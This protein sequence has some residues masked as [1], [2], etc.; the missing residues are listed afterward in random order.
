MRP[1]WF[2]RNLFT[3]LLLTLILALSLAQ[4]GPAFSSQWL[5]SPDSAAP[6]D[7]LWVVRASYSD[8]AMIAQAAS[9]TEPWEVNRQAG[10][11][12]AGVNSRGLEKLKQLG[13]TLEID[14][15]LTRQM[16]AA[17]QPLAGQTSGIP[18]YPCYRTVEETYASA[19]NLVLIAPDLASWIDIGDSWEKTE[20]GGGAG[21][22]LNVLKLTNRNIPGPKPV[23]FIMAAMH[24]REY[25]TAE[26]AMRFAESLVQGYGSDPD[27]TWLLNYQEIHLLL[28]ANPDGRKQAEVGWSWRKNAN[29]NYCG[30]SSSYRG[31]D[32]NRNYE[33]QWGCCGGSTPVACEDTY[34]GPAPASEPETQAVQQYLRQIFPDQRGPEYAD[35]AP[36]TAT[37]LMIDLH[38]YGNLVLWPWGSD[39]YPPA[40]SVDLKTLGHKLAYFNNYTPQQAIELYPTDGT[41]DDFAYGD[42]G[43][44]AYTIELGTQFFQSCSTFENT[45]LPANLQTL[46]AAAKSSRRPYQ[47]PSGPDIVSPAAQPVLAYQGNSV[48][49]TAQ[50]SDLRYKSSNQVPTAAIASAEFTIDVPPWITTTTP[51]TYALQA[52][53]GSFNSKTEVLAASLDTSSLAPGRHTLYL[54]AYDQAGN[55]GPVTALF[56]DVALLQNPVF[57]PVITK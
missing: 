39:P 1:D 27:I 55:L 18:G 36:V 31:A 48:I 15:D 8:P 13:F 56:F 17:P 3:R 32:L 26:L 12:V 22:D 25:T 5:P 33:F 57:L 38:S 54:Q 2:T 50:A 43:L 9:F 49:L 19:Q 29:R 11:L 44:A 6:E 30:Y 53:D 4:V 35:A 37:G 46:L 14:P 42:L 28:Q 47:L 10:Y 7:W 40:N 41:S 23:L 51:V 45:I 20:P 21:Y 52:A 34:R 24:A 16:N